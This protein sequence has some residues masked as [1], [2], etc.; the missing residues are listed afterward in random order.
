MSVP[1]DHHFIPAFYLSKWAK[2]PGDK[3]VE[4]TIKNGTLIG[5]PVG[6]RSTGYEKDLYS[7]PEL[8]P[9]SAQYLEQEFFS[10]LDDTAARAL[11]I[12]LG[13]AGE[14]TNELVNAWSRF[15]L[16]IHLRH[17]DAVPELRAAAKAIWE[18]S[19]PA[20]QKEYAKI[21]QP[22]DPESFDELLASRDPLTDIKMRVNM[23]IK[24]FDNETV[25]SHL[26]KMHKAVVD[27]SS[28]PHTLLLSDR[29][30]CFSNLTKSN[31]VAFLPISPT[32]L[33]VSVNDEKV[34]NQIRLRKT[35]D[36]VKDVNVFVAS[37]ARRF[38]W[39]YDT[40]QESFIR[41]HMSKNMEPTPLFPNL[42]RYETPAA[43]PVGKPA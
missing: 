20:Y 37:R 39:S 30:V 43:L 17:P 28:S 18:K 40:L 38:V 21:R 12:H 13:G 24:S 11:D 26:N 34:F 5:K 29:P 23:I 16:G 42:D 6:P 27:V 33:F 7:F 9:E 41:K 8:P 1:R 10:Y 15:V 2:P 25:V 35:R 22:E 31:G 32:K 19:G 14:W 36:V 4:Y 3:L